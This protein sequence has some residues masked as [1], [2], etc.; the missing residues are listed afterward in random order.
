VNTELKQNLSSSDTWMR[1]LYMLIFAVI[2]SITE[3]VIFAVVVFQFLATLFTGH[4]NQ[5]L[6]DFG[7]ALGTFVYQ[8]LQFVTY[9]SDEK[10]FPFG[11]W[12]QPGKD[13][14]EVVDKPQ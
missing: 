8:I 2:Y 6:L 10:P 12:P 7:A 13:S 9:N 3:F 1:G 5:R 11:A 4:R 14:G